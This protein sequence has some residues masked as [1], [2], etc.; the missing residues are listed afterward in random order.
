[1]TTLINGDGE[2]LKQK[3]IKFKDSLKK[4]ITDYIED[5]LIFLGSLFIISATFLL[6]FV[7]GLYVTGVFLILFG[8]F[9][10]INHPTFKQKRG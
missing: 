8:V 4:K 1:M 5:I 6:S 2:K 7:A 9:F 3:F 10:S